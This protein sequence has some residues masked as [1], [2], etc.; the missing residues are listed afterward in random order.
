[1]ETQDSLL[2]SLFEQKQQ[3]VLFQIQKVTQKAFKE[4]VEREMELFEFELFDAVAI[5]EEQNKKTIEEVR[6]IRRQ[7]W[8]NALMKSNGDKE[9]ALQFF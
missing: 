1:M 2:D 7:R 8:Q 5:S 4:I 3:A 6:K 9:Q